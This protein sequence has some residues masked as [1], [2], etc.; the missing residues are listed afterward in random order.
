MV[1]SAEAYSNIF[2]NVLSQMEDVD[3][4]ELH[5]QRVSVTVWHESND[6]LGLCTSDRYNDAGKAGGTL[7]ET[8]ISQNGERIVACYIY[9]QGTQ[10]KKI[11]NTVSNIQNLWGVISS[12]PLRKSESGY[13]SL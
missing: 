6:N 4:E 7:A 5:N 8:G 10:E 12:F 1:L 9:P 2:T 13:P 3:I 11:I